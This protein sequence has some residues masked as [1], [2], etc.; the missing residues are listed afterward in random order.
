MPR[1]SVEL[2][3]LTRDDTVV[4]AHGRQPSLLLVIERAKCS[5]LGLLPRIRVRVPFALVI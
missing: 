1:Q 5:V 2:G 3:A 4:S